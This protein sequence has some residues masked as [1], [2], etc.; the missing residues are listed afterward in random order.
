MVDV[1]M[2]CV[3][4]LCMHDIYMHS[5]LYKLDL[6]ESINIMCS[7]MV[8]VCMVCVH[9]VFVGVDVYVSMHADVYSCNIYVRYMCA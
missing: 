3:Y 9:V 2:L 8:L 1:G 4:G 5:A 6:C 7:C